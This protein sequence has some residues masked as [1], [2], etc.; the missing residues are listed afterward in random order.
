MDENKLFEEF[1]LYNLTENVE[2]YWKSDDF[3]LDVRYENGSLFRYS[4]MDHSMR[5]LRPDTLKRMCE[6]EEY[7][8]FIFRVNL[9]RMMHKRGVDRQSLS[10]C[11]D[12]SYAT[13]TKYL[14]QYATPSGYNMFRLAE[15]LNC[16]ISEFVRP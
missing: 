2:T 6:D 16:D 8:R 3:E 13:L 7:F 9:E 10:Y 1:C 4:A 12:I 15:A 11:T 14:R 5:R